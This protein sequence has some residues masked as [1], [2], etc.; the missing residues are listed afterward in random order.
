MPK[1]S[2]GRNW[3][4]KNLSLG[5]HEG[6]AVTDRERANEA[7]AKAR[8]ENPIWAKGYTA[9]SWFYLGWQAATEDALERTA[10]RVERLSDHLSAYEIAQQIRA[11]MKEGE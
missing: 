7:F 8:D 11:L 9:D 6:A 4:K 1:Q 2:L 3:K 5:T 10:H